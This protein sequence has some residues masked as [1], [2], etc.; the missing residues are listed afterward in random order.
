MMCEALDLMPSVLG[1]MLDIVLLIMDCWYDGCC[2]FAACMICVSKQK[3][4]EGFIH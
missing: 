3:E 1:G 4:F 2:C